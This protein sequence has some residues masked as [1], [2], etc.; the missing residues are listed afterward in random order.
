VHETWG[1]YA[2]TV[3]HFPEA[4]LTLDLR[5]PVPP[6]TS[7]AF[8]RLGLPGPFA[9]VTACNPLGRI[10]DPAANRR[11]SA[12]LAGVVREQ[13]PGAVRADG[14]APEGG[15]LEPGWALGTSLGQAK[16]LAAR[17][18]QNAV[19]WFEGGRFSIVPVLAEGPIV[20][21]PRKL[22]AP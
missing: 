7:E 8:G 16:R 4:D 1:P 19:F 10:L 18:F 15:H 6:H 5:L 3:L 12:V 17:F 13:H 14:G 21:L 11:L 2:N 22:T 9:V 20:A